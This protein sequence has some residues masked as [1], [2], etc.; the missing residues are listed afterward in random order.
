MKKAT[1]M[2]TVLALFLALGAGWASAQVV[3]GKKFELGTAVN[4]YSFK[5]SGSGSS[6]TYLYVPIQFGWY[7]WK[8]LEIAPEVAFQFPMGNMK[9]LM[10]TCYILSMNVY[11]NFK[12]GQK[13]VPFVGGGAG[14]GN[15]MPYPQYGSIYGGSDIHTSTLDLAGGLK[16]LLSNSI[17]MRLEYRYNRYRWDTSGTI[18]HFNINQ[19]NLGFTYM[20]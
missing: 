3:E 16:Y 11:Y 9:N 12:L 14:F 1:R 15:A 7:V 8:G 17:A 19:V 6:Y 2:L 13:F 5:E 10:D 20:F 18:Y 4:F